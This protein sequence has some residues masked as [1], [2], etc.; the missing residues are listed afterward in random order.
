M[1][2]TC[3]ACRKP[4]DIAADQTVSACTRCGCELA[5]LHAIAQSSDRHLAGA[6]VALRGRHWR[7][8]LRH[9]ERAWALRHQPAA[10]RLAFLASAALGQ[11]ARALHWQGCAADL[12]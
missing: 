1:P 3:P 12:H 6:V 7:N 5:T 4:N 2:L 8:A 9:A 11:T 10:A